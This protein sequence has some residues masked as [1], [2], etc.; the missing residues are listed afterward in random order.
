[1]TTMSGLGAADVGDVRVQRTLPWWGF[2]LANLAVA[3]V[4]AVAAWWL[5]VDPAWSP[6][7]TYP[8][9]FTAAMFWTIISVV[10]VTFNFGWLGP[11]RLSQ[12]ARGLGRVP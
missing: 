11:A 1:M 7:G 10:W 8:Q 4:L 3:A 5:L 12:P 9:P 2:G 6:L